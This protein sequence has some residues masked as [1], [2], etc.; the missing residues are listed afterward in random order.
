VPSE[1][2]DLRDE[3]SAFRLDGT[4]NWYRFEAA[5]T[6][7]CS[8]PLSSAEFE[9]AFDIFERYPKEDGE[10]CGLFWSLLHTLEAHSGYEQFLVASV[11]RVP[12]E[13]GVVMVGRLINASVGEVSGVRLRD[14]LAEIL[15]HPGASSFAKE[16]AQ[17]SL[18]TR[19]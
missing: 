2:K 16:I 13:F 6:E 17:K 10:S 4:S 18:Q 14:L 15:K 3:L 9:A 19:A 11:Q 12:S 8:R 5:L 1:S 7:L